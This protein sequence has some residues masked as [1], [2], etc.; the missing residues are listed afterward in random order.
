M[1]HSHYA[2]ATREALTESEIAA[3]ELAVALPTQVLERLIQEG[4]LNPSELRPLH[5]RAKV[6]IRQYCLSA[7]QGRNCYSCIFQQQCQFK[8]S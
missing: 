1:A 5:P 3:N 2:I 8:S 6:Q 4:R 7:C